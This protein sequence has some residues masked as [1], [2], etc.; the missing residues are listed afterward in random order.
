[1][2]W[3]LPTNTSLG[4]HKVAP[5]LHLESIYGDRKAL[6]VVFIY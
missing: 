1:M 3:Q 2:Q 4:H 5:P 6:R